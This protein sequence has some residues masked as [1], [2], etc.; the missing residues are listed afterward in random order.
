V[1][2]VAGSVRAVSFDLDRLNV[3]GNPVPVVDYVAMKGIGLDVA[4]FAIARNG[5]LVYRTGDAQGAASPSRTLV[6]V[7]RQGHEESLGAPSRRYMYPRLSPDGRKLALDIRDLQ[8]DIWV[9][10]VVRHGPL[11]RLT[12]DPVRHT[13]GAIWSNDG[14]RIAFESDRNTSGSIYWQAD[15]GTGTPEP[16]T[17]RP[18]PHFPSSFTPDGRLLFNDT[19]VGSPIYQLGI[20]TVTGDRHAALLLHGPQDERNGEVSPDGKWLAY[21]SNESKQPAPDVYVRPFPNVEGGR[22]PVSIGGGTRPVWAH[23][24]RELFYAVADDRGS[25]AKIMAVSV[26][27]GS[28]L[29]FGTPHV[30]VDGPYL[31]PQTGRTYDVSGDDKRFLLI[32]DAP[33]TS[34]SAPPPSQLVVVLNWLE[35]LKARVPAK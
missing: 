24:G 14:H 22:W 13:R 11:T 6:W 21:E 8:N 2:A 26:Q 25:T 17:D 35:E 16:L 1:Y 9:W 33:L 4:S 19:P 31:T 20:A 27:P 5:T 23:S 10:D 3:R 12:I 34:S 18:T 28:I 29:T 7:D 32:K 30:V 15:D